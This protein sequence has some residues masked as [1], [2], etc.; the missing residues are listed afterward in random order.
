LFS[1]LKWA[2]EE[3]ALV[4]VVENGEIVI[5]ET[6]SRKRKQRK[7]RIWNDEKTDLLIDLL[8]QNACL[9]DVFSKYHFQNIT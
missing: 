4:D 7:G 8:E 1:V 2:N 3:E 9:W 6:L 5:E